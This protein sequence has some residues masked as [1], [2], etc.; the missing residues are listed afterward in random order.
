MNRD[1]EVYDLEIARRLAAQA[2]ED[3]QRMSKAPWA[4]RDDRIVQSDGTG[5]AFDIDDPG[6]AQGIASIRNHLRATADQL[7]GASAEAERLRELLPCCAQCTQRPAVCFGAYEGGEPNAGPAPAC[8]ACC[9]HGNEDGWCLPIADLPGW[10]ATVEH[11]AELL[12]GECD[13]LREAIIDLLASAVPYP[14]EH[15]TM[16][17]AWSRARELLQ[18]YPPHRGIARPRRER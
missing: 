15:P 3:D 16:S 6:N 17:A 18:K 13:A 9:G 7:T 1:S 14:V 2:H 4:A 11:N 5:I 10:A 12:A 8:D